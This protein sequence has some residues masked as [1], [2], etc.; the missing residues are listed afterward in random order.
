MY[1]ASNAGANGYSKIYQ[2]NNLFDKVRIKIQR[3]IEN[4]I[5]N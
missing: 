4:F 5:L 3:G 2:K 1:D